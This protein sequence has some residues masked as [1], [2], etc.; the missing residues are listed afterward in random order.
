ME[1]NVKIENF[2][3]IYDGY[4]TEQE[5][6][7]AIKLFEDQSKLNKVLNRQV[8][9]GNSSLSKKDL[10]LF[11]NHE[12]IDVW[13]EELKSLIFNF[14]IALKHYEA[15]TGVTKSFGLDELR[16]TNLKIQ[17]TLPGEG[18]HVWHVEHSIGYHNEAR[19]LVFSIYLNDVEDGGETEFL[20]FSK[21]V[22]PKKGR[23]VVVRICERGWS[24]L[25]PPS[26]QPSSRTNPHIRVASE[27][28]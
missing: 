24:T 13:Y 18:Y 9:P 19:A 16:Y 6:D 17:K 5:C 14:D 15:T 21:R 23:I 4:I 2:I 7:N 8:E 11:A 3:G 10:Q 26:S 20:H 12:N 27:C 28:R 25:L 1:R 22:K